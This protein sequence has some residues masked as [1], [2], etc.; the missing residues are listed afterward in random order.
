[1]FVLG[2]KTHDLYSRLKDLISVEC[3]F[4]LDEPTPLSVDSCIQRRMKDVNTP[5]YDDYLEYIDC[6]ADGQEE[7]RKLIASITVNETNF[8]RHPDQFTALRDNVIPEIIDRKLQRG[9]PVE[10]IMS[11]WSAGCST[12]DEPYTIALQVRDCLDPFH[13]NNVEILG[14]DIDED[15]LP[16]ARAGLYTM[17]TLKYVDE[18]HR[19]NYFDPVDGG[20]RVKQDIRR[21]VD[22][23]YHNL[24][25]TP[26]PRAKWQKWDVIFCRNVIIYFDRKTVRC[27]ISNLYDSL[28]EGGY[29][30]LGYSESL[31]GI[32]KNL[33]LCRF[34]DIF[35]YRK[36]SRAESRTRRSEPQPAHHGKQGPLESRK[37]LL[38]ETRK[39]LESEKYDE[40]LLKAEELVRKHP[41][42]AK[43]CS[44]AAR[45]YLEKGCHEEA[46]EAAG[47]AIDIDPLQTHAHFI[48]GVICG[49]QKDYDLSIR[50]LR[51][52]LYLDDT[53]V[54][55]HFQLADIYQKKK[56]NED[57]LREYNNAIRLL[58]RSG[59]DVY[60]EFACGFYPRSILE[61][62]RINIERI[63]GR[64]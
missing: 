41:E 6:H 24:I 50:Y 28:A 56:Q 5:T 36:E 4:Q 1:V 10:P 32:F 20:Y 13:A 52:S 12:G 30:F 46:A 42:D 17:R 23:R 34:G 21:M 51:R 11:V 35:A 44:L 60:L 49:K 55:A 61:M 8:F 64:H 59:P 3:G 19:Q 26:Y 9:T 2:V 22:F 39:L 27:V 53:L 16:H 45:V 63:Q 37:R 43:A 25:K 40:A 38:D 62:C 48:L 7:L 54:M 47:R 33:T 31:N 18:R 15:V 14:T 58:E 57:A 29:L